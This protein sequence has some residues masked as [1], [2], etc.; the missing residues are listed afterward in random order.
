MR[1]LEMINEATSGLPSRYISNGLAS[2]RGLVGD[3]F[4]NSGVGEDFEGSSLGGY[5]RSHT[6]K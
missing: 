2:W 3:I 1:G 4:R 6:N 5:L